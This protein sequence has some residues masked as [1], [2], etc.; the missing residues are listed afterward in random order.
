MQE[1]QMKE[2]NKLK[3]AIIGSGI[4]RFNLCISFDKHHNI[5]LFEKNDYFGGHTHTHSLSDEKENLMLTRDLSFIM[6]IH[7]QIL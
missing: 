6:K 4:S 5:T 1:I 2:H 3:I 7:I